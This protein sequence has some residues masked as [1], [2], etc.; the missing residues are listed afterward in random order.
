MA[1]MRL[2]AKLMAKVNYFLIRFKIH[3]HTFLCVV[4]KLSK[5]FRL[6][7][8]KVSMDGFQI[9]FTSSAVFAFKFYF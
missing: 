8:Y 4:K 2:F 1:L 6:L 7:T 5:G 3:T 9:Q